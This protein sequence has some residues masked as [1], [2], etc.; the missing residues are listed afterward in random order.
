MNQKIEER[1]LTKEEFFELHEQ[2]FGKGS[3]SC[4]EIDDT[5]LC[6][7]VAKKQDAKTASL[8]EAENRELGLLLESEV[9]GIDEFMDWSEEGLRAFRKK[10]LSVVKEYREKLKAGD[11][12][13]LHKYLDDKDTECQQRVE[14]IRTSIEFANKVARAMD[15]LRSSHVF[16]ILQQAFGDTE[17]EEAQDMLNTVIKQTNSWQALKEGIEEIET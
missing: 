4:S 12:G 1:L 2:F 3:C 15:E 14:R 11:L 9:G 16:F 7:L 8:I 5:D 13:I 6:F 10:V 17:W